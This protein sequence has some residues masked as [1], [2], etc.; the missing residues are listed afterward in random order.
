MN[1]EQGACASCW[2]LSTSLRRPL[3]VYTGPQASDVWSFGPV[4]DCRRL[5]RQSWVPTL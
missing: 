3:L 4:T 1:W 5:C 2:Q